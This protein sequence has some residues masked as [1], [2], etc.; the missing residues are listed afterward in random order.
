MVTK[1]NCLAS[2]DIAVT[3]IVHQY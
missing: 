3:M 2:I 1:E